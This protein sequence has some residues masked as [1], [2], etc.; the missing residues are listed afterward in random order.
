MFELGRSSL[1]CASQR[2]E[3][4]MTVLR[5]GSIER[6]F[7]HELP[8][9]A[10]RLGEWVLIRPVAEGNWTQL[11]QA[12]A[13]SASPGSPPQYAV[14]TIRPECFD[15][16]IAQRILAREVEVARMVTHPHIVPVLAW[17][18][19]HPPQYV[20][21]PWLEGVSLRD[22][23]RQR[24]PLPTAEALWLTRQIAE[25]LAALHAAGWIHAD[26]KPENIIVS[27][28]YHV[29]LID[30]GFC[31]R[32][33]E[34]QGRRRLIAGTLNYIAPEWWTMDGRPDARSDLFSLGVILYEMLCGRRPT[35]A[36]T[37]DEL[38]ALHRTWRL[39]AAQ[40]VRGTLPRELVR[41]LRSLLARIPERRPHSAT[42]LIEALYPLE[43]EFFTDRDYSAALEH[44][45]TN[46]VFS[47]H[48]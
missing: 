37:L 6:S 30:L 14:K 2:R 15:S 42:A 34:I 31:V 35:N 17:Q 36:K 38:V 22:L 45:G 46:T 47:R 10:R 26:L 11:Y 23:L 33:S 27:S 40:T 8:V 13:A 43:I 24:S 25:G 29:T 39:P 16:S 21:M 19:R 9:S 20:V 32:Q 1:V 28:D 5:A 44:A 48:C 18:L 3:S 12:Q 4:V 41:L 7:H